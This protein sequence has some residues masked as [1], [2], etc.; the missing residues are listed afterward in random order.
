MKQCNNCIMDTKLFSF[1]SI[2][3]LITIYKLLGTKYRNERRFEF[4]PNDLVIEIASKQ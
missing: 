2:L 1:S 3:A 4:Y